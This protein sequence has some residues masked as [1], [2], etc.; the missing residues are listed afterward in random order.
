[1]GAICRREGPRDRNDDV[2]G[3]GAAK[4]TP[5]EIRVRA[6]ARDRDCKGTPGPRVNPCLPPPPRL[7]IPPQDKALRSEPASF[8]AESISAS[9]PEVLRPSIYWSS[10]ATMTAGHR[11]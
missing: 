8:P 10:T 1:M 2:W 3:L 7:R 11:A 5:A 4:G 9:T 6:G